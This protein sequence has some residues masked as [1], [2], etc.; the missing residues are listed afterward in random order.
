M[1]GRVLGSSKE[2]NG[3]AR[4]VCQVRKRAPKYLKIFSR[5]F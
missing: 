1:S 4:E 3:S 2:G 5:I